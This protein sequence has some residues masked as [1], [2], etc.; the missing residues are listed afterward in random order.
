[1]NFHEY[2]NCRAVYK[3]GNAVTCNSCYG[4]PHRLLGVKMSIAVRWHLGTYYIAMGDISY[5][6]AASKLRDS[7]ALSIHAHSC[8]RPNWV[9]KRWIQL[10]V[11]IKLLRCCVYAGRDEQEGELWLFYWTS[12]S[13]KEEVVLGWMSQVTQSSSSGGF[14]MVLVRLGGRGGGV[15]RKVM[16]QVVLG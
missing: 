13:I 12:S 15:S 6:M 8:S 11:L 1:M 9:G 7:R 14:G 5:V 10:R 4:L 3:G 16:V 2:T